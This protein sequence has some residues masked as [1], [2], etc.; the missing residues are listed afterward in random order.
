MLS[1]EG[2]KVKFVNA[3]DINNKVVESWLG[4]VE[5]MMRLTVRAALFKSVKDYNL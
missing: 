1:L 4:E 3:V 5:E 2:E